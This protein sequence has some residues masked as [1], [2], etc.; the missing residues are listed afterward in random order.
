MRLRRTDGP[1]THGRLTGRLAFTPTGEGHRVTNLE[2]LF[3]LVFVFALTS[4]TGLMAHN[5]SETG[6][7]EGLVILAL[8]WFGWTAYAWLG[9]QARADEGPLRVSMLFA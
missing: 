1:A 8:M 4:V 6:L 5:L 9:N 2:L 7:L 3:D